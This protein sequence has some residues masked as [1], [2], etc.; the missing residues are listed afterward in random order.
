MHLLFTYVFTLIALR[1]I[2]SNY[3][4]FIRAR[5]LFS[6][7]LVHSISARTVM[8][9]H[10]PDHLKGERALAE[11]F[12]HMDLSVESV[13]ICREVGSLKRL[14]DRRTAALLK[15]EKAWVDYV[16]NP[17]VVDL[18]KPTLAPEDRLVDVDTPPDVEAPS[19]LVVVPGRKRPTL[20]PGVFSAKVDKL[21]Y[22]D[23]QFRDAHELVK[24][25]RK[26]GRFKATHVAFVT[27]ETMSSAV[28]H[29]EVARYA[30]PVFTSSIPANSRAGCPLPV[31]AFLPHA[32]RPRA[33]R[34]RMVQHQ[35]L[36]EQSAHPRMGRGLC[37]CRATTL[38]D[39]AYVRAG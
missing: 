1:F 29:H 35:P 4:R 6:L 10:L 17:S 22:L 21:E 15:L 20:R 25:R 13:S 36:P 23:K 5:Q 26:T 30:Y 12:E 27:F 32:P 38:L 3:K 8:I 34:H 37:H 39:S 19:E 31:A 28:S 18:K 2:H 16:C 9:T 7:E 33:A 14:L 24:T 11:Y